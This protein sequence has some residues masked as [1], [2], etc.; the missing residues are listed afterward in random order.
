LEHGR[1]EV[2]DSSLKWIDK[3]GSVIPLPCA[4]ISCIL[5]GPGTTVTQE[6]VKTAAE[7]RCPIHWT[8]EEG[9][10][11]Y[12]CGV[13]T[14]PIQKNAERQA[15]LWAGKSSHLG[16]AKKMFSMRFKEE[17]SSKSINELRGEEGVR[18]KRLY[19]ELSEK[20]GVPWSKRDYDQGNWDKADPINR[21]ISS[22]NACLYAICTSCIKNL[23]Y[24][25]ELGFVH[26][27]TA[28]AF[29]CDIADL[30]KPETSLKAAFQV[31]AGHGNNPEL[32]KL[33]RLQTK[34]LL[35][36]TKHLENLPTL[37]AECLNWE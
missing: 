8:G 1:L 9:T 10:I 27:K 23:G 31:V 5:L 15:T 33:A 34:G 12:A 19:K 18:I 35:E 16:V 6:A 7:S 28:I 36:E 25:P 22:A 37:I 32:E 2:D 3:S 11:L 20:H 13:E 26:S 17:S 24:L 14:G 4:C 30:I 21:A 29:S